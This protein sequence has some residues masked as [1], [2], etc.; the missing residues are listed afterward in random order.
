[1]NKYAIRRLMALLVAAWAAGAAFASGIV[2][3]VTIRQVRPWQGMVEVD[4]E[5]TTDVS[6]KANLATSVVFTDRST[7]KSYTA[8]TFT[9]PFT[10]T[11][12]QK[13][14]I[15]NAAKDGI[16]FKSSDV[17]CTVTVTSGGGGG[18]EGLY[19]IVDLS[20]GTSASSYPVTYVASVPS[21]GWSDEYKTTKLVLRRVD[22]GTFTMGSPSD[23][24]GRWDDETQHQV[25]LT[26][27]FYIGVF[28]V[29]QRQWEL[30]MGTRPSWFNNDTYYASRPVEQVSYNMIRGSSSGS[31]W[32]ASNAVDADSF[33]GKIRAKTGLVFDLPTE[34]QWEYACRAG[35]TTALNSGKNLTS[36]VQDVEMAKVGR[37]WYNGG[38]GFSQSCDTS[39]ATAKVGS[40]APNAWGLYDMHG[41]VWEWCLDWWQSYLGTSAV[42]DPVG[43]ASGDGRD[44][45]GG[46]WRYDAI[47]CRSASRDS[48]N[49]S[50]GPYIFG[51]RL[52]CSAG[53]SK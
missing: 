17:V 20:G 24:L 10:Y 13:R 30:V 4:Y 33:L 39:A 35:T 14:M 26:K 47:L 25:T 40:Y 49:P 2:K 18:S 8:T 51:F 19:C 27:G 42:T 48:I 36:T 12:G 53:S 52:A 23:E 46:N 7:G 11:K 28:E 5:L 45:R 34:A 15:W 50:S 37:Y 38:S 29:T 21:G 41:N 32:P 22:A 16:S 6:S 31:Q 44:L 3:D 9:H 43:P 1:M